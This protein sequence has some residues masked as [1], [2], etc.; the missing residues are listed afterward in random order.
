MTV[1]RI[2][3]GNKWKKKCKSKISIK[4]VKINT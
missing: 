4:T 1:M 3:I 2:Q